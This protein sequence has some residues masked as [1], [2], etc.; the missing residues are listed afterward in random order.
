M[1]KIIKWVASITLGVF[2]FIC[3]AVVGAVYLINSSSGQKLLLDRINPLILGEITISKFNF[4]PFKGTLYLTNAALKDPDGMDVVGFENFFLKVN[5]KS[6][7]KKEVRVSEIR[8]QYPWGRLYI[9]GNGRFNLL[10]AVALKS[11]KKEPP[12]EERSSSKKLPVNIVLDNLTIENGDISFDYPAQ[13]LF[14]DARGINLWADGDF[15]EQLAHLKIELNYFDLKARNIQ[16]PPS[17]LKLAAGLKGK[18]IDLNTFGLTIGA[19]HLNLSGRLADF[20]ELSGLDLKVNSQVSIAELAKI[21]QLEGKWLGQ[22]NL[23]ANITGEV[24]NPN[25]DLKIGLSKGAF[26]NRVWDRMDLAANLSDRRLTIE[27]A[28]AA[29]AQGHITLVGQADL[30][31]A[32]AHGFLKPPVDL[33]QITFDIDVDQ[34]APDVGSWVPEV[35]G[36]GGALESHLSLSGKGASLS[37]LAA[38][39]DLSVNGNG[40]TA[41]GIRHPMK[42]RFH[43]GATIADQVYELKKL[44][45]DIDGIKVNGAGIYDPKNRSVTGQL[46]LD[47]EDLSQPLTLV[48]LPDAR[49][50]VAL[51][52]DLAGALKR[53]R[54][55]LTLNSKNLG[56]GKISIGT[57]DLAAV[58]SPDG[59]L[60]ISSLKLVNR[61]STVNGRVQ[62]GFLEGWKGIDPTY[63]QKI[64]LNLNG[65]E[66][67]NFY[68]QE[69]V[70]GQLDGKIFL[71]GLLNDLKG[72]AELSAKNVAAETI[73]VGDLSTRVSLDGRLLQ[74]E[75]LSLQNRKSALK[76]HGR[77]LLL[78]DR[79]GKLPADPEFQLSL[80]SEQICP[81]DFLDGVKGNFLLDA[82]LDGT[83]KHPRGFVAL[84]GKDIE[85]VAQKISTVDLSA[86]IDDDR[87][88][89][90]PLEITV[91]KDERVVFTGWA[92]KDLSFGFQ[93]TSDGV[94]LS[95]VDAIKKIN[96][97]RGRVKAY[98][99]GY[100]NLKNP[101]ADGSLLL[102][103][104]EMNKQSFDD[105]RLHL[106]LHDH[107]LNAYGSLDFDLD[108][109]YHLLKKEFAAQLDFY[110]TQLNPY[111]RIAG[112]PDLNG[113]ISGKV[114]VSGS[115]DRPADLTADLDLKD[116]ALFRKKKRLLHTEKVRA[117]MTGQHLRLEDTYVSLLSKGELAVQGAARLNGPVDVSLTV[118]QPISDAA[119]FS[120][121]LV[122]SK[123]EVFLDAHITG[124]LPRPQ[125]KGQVKLADIALTI[126]ANTQRVEK[127]NGN[128][129]FNPEEINVKDLKGKLDTGSFGL[130]GNIRHQFFT[131]QKMDLN[132]YAD[133]LPVEV[134][135]TISLLLN[136]RI[137]I[138]GEGENAA[139]KGKIV[140][141]NGSYYKDVKIDLSFLENIGKR[142]RSI[143]P[144]AEPLK[145]PFLKTIDLKIDVS[146]R[147]PFLVQNN[148]AEM[149]IRPDLSVG[150]TLNQPVVSGRA[151]VTEGT[152][153]FKKR[154]FTINKG[155]I[156]FVNPY[157]TEMSIDIESSAEIRDWT[158][159]LMVK[160]TPDNLEFRLSSE[161]ALS[162]DDILTL[163]I[164]GKTR[165]EFSN[166]ESKGTK[167]TNELLAGLIADTFSDELKGAT[168]MDI[169]ELEAGAEAGTEDDAD[170]SSDRVKVTVGKHLSDRMTFKVSMEP[171]DGKTVLRYMPEYKI[172]DNI[173]VSAFR[174]TRGK[175]GGELVFRIEFR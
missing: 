27:K 138:S 9:D 74:L 7:L 64:S 154:I 45:G 98:I 67:R 62:L 53:P 72:T 158:I 170:A 155:V 99:S 23:A 30:K 1:K 39:L 63:H 122:D 134:P 143:S 89:L 135:D 71:S 174:D 59:I 100:G 65:I 49:G 86:R 81:E 73:R 16:V 151:K 76:A 84:N 106:S 19:S 32:F 123:G 161:P 129:L 124:S 141:L 113:T 87:V 17:N 95:S 163:L 160:G 119:D 58:L 13:E 166:G 44:D 150:G 38:K 56:Y 104:I 24:Q 42:G 11:G 114:T 139:A 70:Q 128:I 31:G 78:D 69:I 131:P 12:K 125:I 116:V 8:L 79:F 110:Q 14:F 115:V 80:S 130:N 103:K 29:S 55:N 162:D 142:S 33:D 92:K 48:G 156:D 148:L 83:L 77:I 164:F 21:F 85:T 52:L 171:E 136:S 137:K 108:G 112:Q 126:P 105:F 18:E 121:M 133:A 60:D 167:S 109:S 101:S 43:L 102:E 82:Q 165:T 168:G 75:E 140:L 118:R 169:L 147:E 117:H 91:A 22:A 36:L 10:N 34:M 153:T 175:F 66:V 93:L 20:L 127:L 145:L 28:I 159:N 88:E 96:G 51:S 15:L 90:S 26:F 2:V 94:D 144:P 4:S 97:F 40:L 3:L 132:F 68:D 173:L 50:N 35:D 146:Y 107:L 157:K 46:M 54:L 61:G 57:I 37:G 152:L 6:L 149:E 120:E 25:V 47:A 5:W 172:F 111:L 41:T